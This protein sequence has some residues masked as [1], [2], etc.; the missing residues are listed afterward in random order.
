[1]GQ[2]GSNQE[3]KPDRVD[4]IKPLIAGVAV[5]TQPA[6]DESCN[7]PDMKDGSELGPASEINMEI[8]TDKETDQVRRKEEKNKD[9]DEMETRSNSSESVNDAPDDENFKGGTEKSTKSESVG[10]TEI[11]GG[12]KSKHDTFNGLVGEICE[13][14]HHKKSTLDP[15]MHPASDMED[16]DDSKK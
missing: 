3:K 6:K 9:V 16:D 12:E 1:M 15:H 13:K 2:L 4:K 7:V 10:Y 5:V 11:K 14:T 8:G